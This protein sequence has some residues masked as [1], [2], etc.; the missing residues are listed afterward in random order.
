MFILGM[1]FCHLVSYDWFKKSRK[2]HKDLKNKI[3]SIDKQAKE[4]LLSEDSSEIIS[5]ASGNGEYLSLAILHK[6]VK[7]IVELG[8]SI[9]AHEISR[10]I[11]QDIRS[12]KDEILNQ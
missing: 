2:L 9:V 8:P 10:D 5:F 4:I 6:L 3:K 7:R 11:D 12:D 1:I